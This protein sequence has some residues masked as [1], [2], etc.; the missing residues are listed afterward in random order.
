MLP[1]LE[2]FLWNAIKDAEGHSE[3][4]TEPGTLTCI[5]DD[6]KFKITIHDVEVVE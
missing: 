1:A 3:T 4:T 5:V 2:E 6:W